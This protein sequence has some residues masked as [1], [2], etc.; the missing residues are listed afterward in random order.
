MKRIAMPAT[1][2]NLLRLEEELSFARSGLDLLDRE[3]EIL[4]HQVASLSARADRVRQEVNRGLAEA[5]GQLWEAKIEFGESMV[6]SA[7]LGLKAGEHLSI[8]EKS[9]MGVVLPL[10]AIDLPPLRPSYGLYAT[11]KSIDAT[12]AAIHRVMEIFQP[13]TAS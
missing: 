7:G 3:K 4:V 8:R 2:S 1:R 10:V 9:L 11:G 5:Y 13:P 12:A 6:E